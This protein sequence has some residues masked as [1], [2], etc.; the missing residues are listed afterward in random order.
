MIRNARPKSTRARSSEL[1]NAQ[2][3]AQMRASSVAI[4]DG[5]DLSEEESSAASRSGTPEAEVIVIAEDPQHMLEGGWESLLDPG[6]EER[7]GR[8]RVRGGRL[9]R[10]Q[11]LHG[12]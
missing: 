6:A 4:G 9:R 2:R 5:A 12:P 8:S 3:W 10:L 1:K 11:K 7:L